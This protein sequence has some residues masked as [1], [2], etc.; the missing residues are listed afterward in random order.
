MKNIKI[1]DE[2]EKKNYRYKD[3]D[4]NSTFIQAYYYSKEAENELINFGDVIWDYDIDEIVENCKRNGIEE[5]TIS[6]TFSSLLTTIAEFEKRDCHMIKL[7]EINS[8]YNDW[9]AG[10]EGKVQ[11]ERIPALLMRMGK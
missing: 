7:V 2:A 3:V 9:R 4:L 6:S 5:F 11:K 1:L 10:L 8:K